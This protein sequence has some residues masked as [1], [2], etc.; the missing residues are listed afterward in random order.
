MNTTSFLD[1]D[2]VPLSN[3]TIELLVTRSAGPRIIRL[4]LVGQENM[5]AELPEMNLECPDSGELRLLGGHRLWH[6]PEVRRRTYLPDDQPVDISEVE[7][8]LLAIQPVEEKTGIQKRMQITMPTDSA[9]VIIDHTL[10]NQGLWPV[11]LAPWAITQIKPGGMALL[12]QVTDALDA[13]GLLPNRQVVLWPYTDI[14]SSHIRWGNR[15]IFIHATG[16]GASG[17]LKIG[18]P[19]RRGWL[20][21]H[22]DKTLF[23]KQTAYQPGADY[24]DYGSSTECYYRAEFIELETLG[25]I[26]RLEPGQLVTH[27]ETWRLFSHIDFEPTEEAAAEMAASLGL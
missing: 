12:P 8:G 3:G 15:F 21:Y 11:E 4:N 27:R 17:P 6:A 16:E 24:Y 25:P 1:M 23:V 19:N 7:H 13:D 14:N 18:Y 2:C 10:T 22:I 26:T 9:T 5:L 20:A